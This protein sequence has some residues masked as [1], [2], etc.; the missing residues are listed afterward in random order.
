MNITNYVMEKVESNN[1]NNNKEHMCVY[2]SKPQN[3]RKQATNAI[4]TGSKNGRKAH[5]CT[6]EREALL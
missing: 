6:G 4:K 2:V 1:N 3:L 5:I